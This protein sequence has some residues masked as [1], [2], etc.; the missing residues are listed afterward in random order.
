M[1]LYQTYSCA[2]YS[3]LLT[4]LPAEKESF[5]ENAKYVENLESLD[6]QIKLFLVKSV[7]ESVSNIQH[8]NGAYK[9][10]KK[11]LAIEE[12]IKS[13]TIGLDALRGIEREKIKALEEEKVKL[14]QKKNEKKEETINNGL[15]LFGFLVVISSILDAINL[16][17]WFLNDENKIH[18][19]HIISIGGIGLLTSVVLGIWIFNKWK[20]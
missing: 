19:G 12:D 5:E 2:H 18:L 4:K 20:K 15:I 3:R 6:N 11:V 13:L 17:D 8:Q 1:L 16:V 7:Y 9:Y 10:G 14:D